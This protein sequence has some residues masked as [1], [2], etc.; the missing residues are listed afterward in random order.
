MNIMVPVLYMESNPSS[1]IKGRGTALNPPVRLLGPLA[2][3]NVVVHAAMIV[4]L[5]V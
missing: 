2:S 4:S 1:A 3:K 5:P